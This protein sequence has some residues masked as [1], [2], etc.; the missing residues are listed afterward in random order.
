MKE[1]ST[2][3]K[4]TKFQII[5]CQKYNITSFQKSELVFNKFTKDIDSI[6]G[7][8]DWTNEWMKFDIVFCHNWAFHNQKYYRSPNRYTNN[9]YTTYSTNEIFYDAHQSSLIA[10]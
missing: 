4:Y 7:I 2:T 9:D 5:Y 10:T 6:V 8:H 1:I 3:M